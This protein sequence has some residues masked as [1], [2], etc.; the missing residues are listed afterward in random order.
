[1]ADGKWK[2]ANAWKLFSIYYLAFSIQAGNS[3]RP[4]GPVR[5]PSGVAGRIASALAVVLSAY[6][7]YWV[8]F[9][10]QPQ[11]YRVSFL[12]LSLVMTF[13]LFPLRRHAT[14]A[15]RVSVL[16]WLLAAS[17]AI[18]LSWPLVDFGSFIYRAADPWRIDVILGAVTVALVLEATRR[19]TGWILPAT[20]AAFLVYAYAGP[21]FDRLGLPLIAHRG[22]GI[23]RLA[24]TLYMTLE[25]LFGV[26]LDVAA[27]YIV[28]FTIYGAVLE[29]SGAGAFFIEWAMAVMG[30]SRSAAAPGR[31]VTLAGFLLGTV[32]GSGVATT[33][34]LGSVAWPLLRRAG[35]PPEVGGAMLSVMT[36]IQRV[37]RRQTEVVNMQGSLRSGYQ[38]VQAEL[39]DWARHRP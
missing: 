16:D 5:S 24:G 34:T 33:V 4:D 27:T 36:N 38:L 22:Y 15:T 39:A 1:M 13:L 11:I 29:R 7:L 37:T 23:D 21:A 31:T 17:A 3:Q 12:L 10:V 28:L 9:I 35:F 26:P 8:L 14:D 32:S 20:A 30:R 6:A 19:S 18:A 2:N 25:G